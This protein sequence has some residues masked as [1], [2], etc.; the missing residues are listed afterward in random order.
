M[1]EY[2]WDKCVNLFNSLNDGKRLKFDQVMKVWMLQGLNRV[3]DESASFEYRQL[4]GQRA[5]AMVNG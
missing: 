5:V 3:K 1:F 4:I 2:Y